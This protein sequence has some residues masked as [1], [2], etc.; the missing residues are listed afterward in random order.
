MGW[1]DFI[2]LLFRE[3][4]GGTQEGADGRTKVSNISK[5]LMI[6]AIKALETRIARG[7]TQ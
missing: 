4:T 2:A 1:Q 7:G 6:G 5:L 3:N